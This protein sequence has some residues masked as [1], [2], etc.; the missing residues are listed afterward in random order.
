MS[1]SDA[2]TTKGKQQPYARMELDRKRAKKARA[3]KPGQIV[4]VTLVGTITNLA[5]RSSSDPE[6]GGFEGNMSLDIQDMEIGLSKK[7][8]I[9]ELL[10]E[11]E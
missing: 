9:A 10:D 11:D 7:N 5:F 4:R 3:F 8:E 2:F 1:L 6:K